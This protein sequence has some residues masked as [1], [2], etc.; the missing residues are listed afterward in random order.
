MSVLADEVSL[1]PMQP[2]VHFFYPSDLDPSFP[3]KPGTPSRKDFLDIANE[4]SNKWKMLGRVL[5]VPEHVLEEIEEGNRDL[6][7][8]RYREYKRS[9]E[10][11]ACIVTRAIVLV[12]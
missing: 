8:R 2:T 6:S 10:E 5:Q 4:L 11:V 7:E 1:L 9:K 12:K 3:C